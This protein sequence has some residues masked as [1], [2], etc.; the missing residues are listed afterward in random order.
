MLSRFSVIWFASIEVLGRLL[1]ELVPWNQLSTCTNN[2]IACAQLN[3]MKWFVVFH[4]SWFQNVFRLCFSPCELL[5]IF[6]FLTFSERLVSYPL[7]FFFSH[8]FNKCSVLHMVLTLH[9]KGNPAFPLCFF[10]PWFFICSVCFGLFTLVFDGF[11][12]Y[13]KIFVL[14]YATRC[15]NF[16]N[17]WMSRTQIEYFT[18]SLGIEDARAQV[19]YSSGDALLC[20]AVFSFSL[21]LW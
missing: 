4:F 15:F 6:I 1:S 18:I 21:R 2:T 16:I 7:L 17:V 13:M 3:W 14:F 9:R 12:R 19:V 10:L 11:L 8:S 20:V 5:Y